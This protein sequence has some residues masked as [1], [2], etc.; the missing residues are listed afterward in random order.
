MAVGSRDGNMIRPS[1]LSVGPQCGP[2]T[3]LDDRVD[4]LSAAAVSC[5]DPDQPKVNWKGTGVT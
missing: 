3:G 1:R 5:H 2:Q 4:M